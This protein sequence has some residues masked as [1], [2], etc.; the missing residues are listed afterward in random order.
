M[1]RALQSAQ[2]NYSGGIFSTHPALNERI[3]RAD[4]QAAGYR[5]AGSSS[6]RRERFLRIVKNEK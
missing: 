4:R 6:A 3:I 2:K 1:L 5:R